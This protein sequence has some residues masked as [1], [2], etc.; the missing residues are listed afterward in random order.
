MPG[1]SL[2]VRLFSR[3]FRG[4]LVEDPC[5]VPGTSE[6]APQLRSILEREAPGIAHARDPQ[7]RSRLAEAM[8]EQGVT[9]S[10]LQLAALLLERAVA[11]A[12][13]DLPAGRR[14]G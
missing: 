10:P 14:K 9:V 7:R 12:N 1:H 3:D 6:R 13:E 2:A 5:K 8:R 4:W 11:E